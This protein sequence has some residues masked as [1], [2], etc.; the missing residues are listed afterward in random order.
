MAFDAELEK[1]IREQLDRDEIFRVMQ[2]Y[3]RGLDRLDRELARAEVVAF[4]LV[5]SKPNDCCFAAKTHGA[6]LLMS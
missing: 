5:L 2:R 3:A 4:G 6:L 1:R